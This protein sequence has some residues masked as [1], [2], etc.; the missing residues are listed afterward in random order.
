[1]YGG[2][3]TYADNSTNWDDWHY[4]SG[5]KVEKNNFVADRLTVRNE[6]D[7][8]KVGV[9]GSQ[10]GSN[11]RLSRSLI[12]G[13]HDDCFQNDEGLGG[14][15]LQ[16]DFFSSCYS[17][18]SARPSSSINASNKLMIIDSSIIN[19]EVKDSCYKPSKYGC[20]N[21][22]GFLKWDESSNGLKLVL[23][24]NTFATS[25]YP[26]IGSMEMNAPIATIGNGR[27]DNCHGNVIDWLGAPS[28]PE[29]EDAFADFLT[30]LPRCPDTIFNAGTAATAHYLVTVILWNQAHAADLG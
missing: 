25:S 27:T 26:E 29:F 2:T 15:V 28:G 30:W 19:T 9:N 16:Q 13:T 18:I 17:G 21:H 4:R 20:P 10:G 22:A 24:N 11:F 1:M 12:D 6:G 23:W 7:A 5:L 14:I 3:I 8:V